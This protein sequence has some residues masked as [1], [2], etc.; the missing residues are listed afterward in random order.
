MMS[1]FL[2]ANHTKLHADAN[3]LAGHTDGPVVLELIG[4]PV[5]VGKMLVVVVGWSVVHLI[6]SSDCGVRGSAHQL[7]IYMRPP[8]V[9][10]HTYY[11]QYTI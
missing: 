10:K 5:V 4:R 3:A 2:Y 11:I 7:F 1:P 9:V 6:L 8:T